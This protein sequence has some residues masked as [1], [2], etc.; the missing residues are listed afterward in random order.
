M[1]SQQPAKS[2]RRT[3]G[4]VPFLV[5]LG[6]IVVAGMAGLLLLSISIQT[7]S[8]QLRQTQAQVKALSDEAALLSAEADRVGSVTNLAQ[9]A[10]GLGM[11]PNPHGAFLTLPDGTVSGDTKPV[12]GKEL[13]GIM[14]PSSA[15]QPPVQV[16]IYPVPSTAVPADGPI[17]GAPPTPSATPT[18]TPTTTATPTPSATPTATP[19][20]RATP[21]VPPTPSAGQR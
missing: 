19:T 21:T 18:A 20:P 15:V 10:A 1:S 14:P 4:Q 9:Q 6:A 11:R 2:Q 3:L 16:K 12:T 5:G 7:G 17:E 8:V 13:P